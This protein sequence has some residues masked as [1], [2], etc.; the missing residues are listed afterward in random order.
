MTTGELI[1]AARKKAG[2]TQAELAQKL[3]ISYVGVSQWERGLRNPKIETLNR[4]AA[5]LGLEDETPLPPLFGP[6]PTLEDSRRENLL[7]FYDHLLNEE[8]KREAVKR[9]QELTEISRYQAPKSPPPSPGESQESR[10][11]V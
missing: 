1:K 8:G 9:I 5:A 3:G 7:A 2:M 6:S 4:I 11:R 10:R